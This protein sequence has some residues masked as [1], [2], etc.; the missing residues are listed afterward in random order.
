MID[1]KIMVDNMTDKKDKKEETTLME[2]FEPH[3]ILS[4]TLD[5]NLVFIRMQMQNGEWVYFTLSEPKVMA[6][7]DILKDTLRD[8]GE[9]DE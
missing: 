8:W 1:H 5:A 6:L 4:D 9:P 3:L 7:I 2:K